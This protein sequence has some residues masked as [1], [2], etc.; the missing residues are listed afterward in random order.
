[1]KYTQNR[2]RYTQKTAEDK[3]KILKTA[4]VKQKD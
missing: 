2:Y 3:E 4:R 1:M